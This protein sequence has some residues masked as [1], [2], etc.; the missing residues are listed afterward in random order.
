VL[1]VTP[2]DGEFWEGSGTAIS[3][4]KMATA[5]ITGNRPDMGENRKVGMR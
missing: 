5:A 3:Y 2:Q 1:K 4:V